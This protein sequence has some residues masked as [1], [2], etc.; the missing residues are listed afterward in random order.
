MIKTLL[1]ITIAL[2]SGNY[3]TYSH[4]T[5]VMESMDECKAARMVEA[6]SL[7]PRDWLT[8]QNDFKWEA[9]EPGI[10]GFSK[11]K[12]ECLPIDNSAW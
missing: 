1:I 6:Q 3:S 5:T 7:F 11:Y 12:L 2:G 10:W 9:R 8:T 4:E